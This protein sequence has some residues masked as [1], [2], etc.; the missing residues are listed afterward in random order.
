MLQLLVGWSL[1]AGVSDQLYLAWVSEV[2]K[3]A[4]LPATVGEKLSPNDLARLADARPVL[5]YRE[6]TC[7]VRLDDG[8]TW[9]GSKQGVMY[10]TP[11]MGRWRLF[12]SRRWLPNNQVD[13]LAVDSTGTVWVKTP[14]G[15]A[16]LARR[17]MTLD[18]KMAQ[19]DEQLQQHH[20]RLGLVGSIELVDPSK[21]SAG[22]WQPSSDNDG[23]WTSLYVAAEAFR[24]GTTADPAAKKNAAASLKALMLLEEI[25][26]IPGFCARSFYPADAPFKPAERHGGEWHL[27]KDGNWW[28]K[29]DTSS[30]ELDGHY[31]AYALYYDIAA[32]EAERKQI[33]ALVARIT[34][35]IIDHGYYY[36]GPSGNPTTWG[37]WAPERLNQD[38]KWFGD[39]GLNSLEI[40]SH[41]KVA[42]HVTGDPKYTRAAKEL[43]E[44]HSYA[45][46]TVD[47]K[48]VWPSE[49][50]NH[51]DDE[52]AFLA[53]YP[54][55]WYERDPEL[56]RIYLASLE[57]S[58][59]IERPEQSPFFNFI[60]AACRQAG[61]VEDASKRPDKPHLAPADYDRD[62][63]VEWFREVPSDLYEWS[64]VNSNRQDLGEVATNR[65]Q[66]RRSHF[67]LPI[68]ERR[69]MRW[70]GDP[71]E[72]DGGS[73]GR[74]R[75]DG[76]FIL[77]PYWMGRY[78]RFI[79]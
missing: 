61:F 10:R 58:W 39:R 46:N 11:Q 14:A 7:G 51:S 13:D 4:A 57:R 30:D 59:Q 3:E 22:W 2:S 25:T 79:D 77:L 50:V 65:F 5:P 40:L 35:H 72:L 21:P 29:G 19:I 62:I 8:A 18:K 55:L 28:W 37:V 33:A 1:L 49:A 43:V 63:C 71:Y 69:V 45:I 20:V 38:L 27:S 48:Q 32:D 34:D 9:V 54:L 36:V 68:A 78:H 64:V 16:K 23:L 12:H 41:L 26:G 74:S 47:Q 75:D 60:Y 6:L 31:F 66:Q 53:Y 67:V 70:N 17:E 15:I 73:D 44:K 42:E 76:T 52:L 56:R 24:Y